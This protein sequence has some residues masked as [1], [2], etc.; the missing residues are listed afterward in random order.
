MGSN[1]IPIT[2]FEDV[3]QSLEITDFVEETLG[4]QQMS[5]IYGE[6]NSGKTF[7]IMDM[8]FHVA[9]G[10][11]WRGLDVDQGAVIYCALEGAHGIT[12]RVAAL[13]LHYRDRI[14]EEKV[15]FG[16]ITVGLNLLDPEADTQRAC[17]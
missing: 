10:W 9:M 12:N 11:K 6:S 13:K 4:R 2:W 14:G 15:Q 3:R 8:A 16:V 5:V 1:V 7:F 17:N